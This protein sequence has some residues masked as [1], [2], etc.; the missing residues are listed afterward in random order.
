MAAPY[1]R[2]VI[3]GITIR[4]QEECNLSQRLFIEEQV[5]LVEKQSIKVDK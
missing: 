3:L 4:I 2:Q 1:S 5:T